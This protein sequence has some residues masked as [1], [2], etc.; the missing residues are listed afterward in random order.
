M[1]IQI[2]AVTWLILL[3][4]FVVLEAVSVAL[5]SVWFVGGSLAALLT[6][7]VTDNVWIQIAVFAGVSFVLLLTVRPIAAKLT[8]K[9]L[10]Q[11][12]SGAQTL[13]GKRAVVTQ[14]IDNLASRGEVQVNGQLWSARALKDRETF[15]KDEVVIIRKIDG[16]K[17]LVEKDPAAADRPESR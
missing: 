8:G 7:F 14:D 3:I 12:V 15:G 5:V 10:N 2:Q 11:V 9:N 17:L 13:V 6:T 1:E 4:L 16:V